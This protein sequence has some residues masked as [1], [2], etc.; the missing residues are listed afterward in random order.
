MSLT[1]KVKN[2]RNVVLSAATGYYSWSDGR[3]PRLRRNL[4]GRQTPRGHGKI[5]WPD[6]ALYEGKFRKECAR[7]T[8]LICLATAVGILVPGEMVGTVA[9][10]LVL[11]LVLGRM[12]AATR[13]NG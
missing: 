8:V 13:V 11:V 5:S 2:S 12:D 9:L 6:G 3:R 1:T 10:A 7:V 4:S